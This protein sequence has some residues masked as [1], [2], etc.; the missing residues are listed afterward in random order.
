M[1]SSAGRERGTSFLLAQIFKSCPPSASLQPWVE[2]ETKTRIPSRCLALHYPSDI[3][4]SCESGSNPFLNKHFVIFSS[5]WFARVFLFIYLGIYVLSSPSQITAAS[6]HSCEHK[7]LYN[8]VKATYSSLMP[9]TSLMSSQLG[10]WAR[11]IHGWETTKYDWDCY[12]AECNGKPFLLI[13]CLENPDR[14][15][16]MGVATSQLLLN[17]RLHLY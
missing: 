5:G 15:H 7:F 13:S 10:N 17:G 4:L 2:R 12:A 1:P 16:L 3:C 14:W 11:L 6:I 9:H 8:S